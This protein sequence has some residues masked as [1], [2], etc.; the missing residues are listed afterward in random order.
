MMKKNLFRGVSDLWKSAS[1]CLRMFWILA[2]AFFVVGLG[3]LGTVRTTGDS[4][5]LASKKSG[6][7]KDPAIVFRVTPPEDMSASNLYVTKVYV[8][9]GTIYGEIG[10]TATLRLSRASSATAAFPSGTTTSSSIVFQNLG[11]ASED[12]AVSNALFNWTAFDITAVSTAGWRVSTY[13]YYQ[14]TSRT[15]NV[16]INEIVFVAEDTSLAAEDRTQVLLTAEINSA[17]VLPY[18]EDGSPETARK[19]AEAVLDSQYIPSSAQSSF[20]RFTEEEAYSM[21]SVAEVRAGSAYTSGNVYHVDGTYNTLGTDL[22]TLGT[23]IFGMSPFGLRILPF[24]ASF[25]LLIAG[26]FFLRRLLHSDR[27][28]VV[29]SFLY[30]FSGMAIVFGHLGT[31]LMIGAFFFILS[32]SFCYRFYAEG[33]KAANFRS[34]LP[35]FFSGLFSA[36]AICVNGAFVIPVAGVAALFVAGLVRQGKARRYY[37]DLAIEQAEAEERSQPSQAA[38]EETEEPVLSEGKKKVLEVLGEY[39]Y[40]NSVASAV[41]FSLLVLGTLVLSVLSMLP[42]YFSFVKVFDQPDSPTR[43]V[44]SL[45]WKAFAGGFAGEN[46]LSQSAWS[47]F[48]S[49]FSGTGSFYAVTATGLIPALIPALAGIFGIVFSVF[50]I[51]NICR[52]KQ[53][54]K[55]AHT[56]LRM[57][58]I[59]LGGFVLSL[60]TSFA[61]KNGALFVFLC[62]FFA[63]LLATVSWH[64][65][66][67]DAKAC[68]KEKGLRAAEKVCLALLIVAFVLFA[69]VTF[70]IPLPSAAMAIF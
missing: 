28:G 6:D 8:N 40:K 2:L 48:Y 4:Y 47:V 36:A 38:A 62:Y 11:E 41:F 7:A 52:K 58:L 23:L 13:P 59:L 12:D 19:S 26:F 20:F 25:G 61:A 68:G 32:L 35:L 16:L 65:L 64:T 33:M 49:L 39:R 57:L 45:M 34:A 43:S 63:F 15:C 14:L 55:Q 46:P 56:S 30:V 42:T 27:A 10:S 51:A 21:M 29:F 44:F 67:A 66:E 18:G 53:T 24:L 3:T 50:R 60:V 31:P 54:D 5:E 37:L 22:L 1:K 9:I 69:I 17:S 70:S